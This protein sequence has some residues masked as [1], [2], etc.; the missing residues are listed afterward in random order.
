MS[1]GNVAIRYNVDIS[2]RID[3]NKTG[4]SKGCII[5]HFWY[6]KD[7]GYKFEPHVCNSCHNILM[8]AHEF[9]K[10]VN[11]ECKRLLL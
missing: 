11:T 6:F 8:M 3:I 7:I 5:F 10:N 4:A 9:K 2:E 1:Y